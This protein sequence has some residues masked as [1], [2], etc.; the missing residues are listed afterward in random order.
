M[1]GPDGTFVV[2]CV[3]GDSRTL[4]SGGTLSSPS[5]VFH[6][7]MKRKTKRLK[8]FIESPGDHVVCEARALESCLAL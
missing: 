4:R 2:L 1:S 3:S 8:L 7:L 5:F 6:L